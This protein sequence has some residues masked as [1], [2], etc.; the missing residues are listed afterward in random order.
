MMQPLQRLH[1]STRTDASGALAPKQWRILVADDAEFVRVAL[2]AALSFA[3]GVEVVCARN[4]KEALDLLADRARFDAVVLDLNMPILDGREVLRRLVA[5][6]GPLPYIIAL[7]PQCE[8]SARD[9]SIVSSADYVLT[10]PLDVQRLRHILH[11]AWSQKA[12]T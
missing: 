3:H 4:G 12:R 8:R 9:D 11:E 2:L 10:K 1:C 6:G 5:R 7:A